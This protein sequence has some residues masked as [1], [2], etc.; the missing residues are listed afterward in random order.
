M[1]DCGWIKIHRKLL[2][3]PLFRNPDLLRTWVYF[4]LKATHRP[5]KQVVGFQEV[6]LEPGQFVFG[7]KKAAQDIGISEQTLRT[8]LKYLLIHENLTIKATNKFSVITIVNWHIYQSGED[9]DNQ[10]IN[11]RLTSSQPTTNQQVTTNKNDKNVKKKEK[12]L[13][14]SGP[15][16]H[17][18][19]E[20]EAEEGRP[21][22]YLTKKKK[23]L[24]GKRLESFNAFWEAWNFQT[25]WCKAKSDAADAWLEIPSLTAK[26]V[27]QICDAAREMGR[28]RV[29]RTTERD[30]TPI[31]PASWLRARRYE[32]YVESKKFDAAP[33][34]HNDGYQ[35]VTE[36]PEYQE[37]RERN[38]STAL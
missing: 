31:Y 10:Q 36:D 18:P 3:S 16:D 1:G 25:P 19:A 7:R 22:F 34:P 6:D 9:G 35:D 21:A 8:C 32:D 26:L 23:R 4:L 38:G 14:S 29:L 13:S 28:T 5:I 12:D 20:P 37:W 17:P 27:S 11:Q 33:K 15:T 30:S 2:E 24:E